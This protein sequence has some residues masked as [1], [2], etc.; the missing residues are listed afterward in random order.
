[1]PGKYS[2]E[3][4]DVR[5]SLR[6]RPRPWRQSLL[7]FLTTVTTT[8]A[9]AFQPPWKNLQTLSP[10]INN[11]NSGINC[12]V[13]INSIRRPCAASTGASGAWGPLLARVSGPGTLEAGLFML[14]TSLR[15]HRQ[16]QRQCQRERVFRLGRDGLLGTAHEEGGI[17]VPW[18]MLSAAVDAGAGIMAQNGEDRTR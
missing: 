18:G 16:K 10:N 11:I 12:G 3:Y 17:R 5:G 2:R 1:M 9:F 13:I 14:G 8:A 6:F 15:F 7:S 4:K